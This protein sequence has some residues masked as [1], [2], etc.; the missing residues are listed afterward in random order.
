M[1]PTSPKQSKEDLY[2]QA[3]NSKM[4]ANSLRE[5]NLRLATRM[6]FVE[7]KLTSTDASGH[8]N[9][10]LKQLRMLKQKYSALSHEFKSQQSMLKTT[11][12]NETRAENELYK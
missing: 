4:E 12:V 10:L 9:M 3:L 2:A 6:Q 7:N 5:E 11:Q 8:I 1:M